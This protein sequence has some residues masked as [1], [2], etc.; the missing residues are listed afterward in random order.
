MEQPADQ[1]TR[2]NADTLRVLPNDTLIIKCLLTISVNK[3]VII[4][5]VDSTIPGFP[6]VLKVIPAKLG[7]YWNKNYRRLPCYG[8]KIRSP[9][10][11][12]SA[13]AQRATATGVI[14][15]APS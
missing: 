13:P 4:G 9:A 3:H 2:C 7:G 15:S 1:D 5:D 10:V 6:A 14:E 11:S 8:L 12:F